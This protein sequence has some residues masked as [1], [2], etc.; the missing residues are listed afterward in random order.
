MPREV[1]FLKSAEKEYQD[2]TSLIQNDILEKAVTLAEFPFCGPLMG[3][4]YQGYRYLLAFRRQ[5]R[6]IYRVLEDETVEIAYIRHCKRQL[7]LRV[8]E[9]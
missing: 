1:R 7:G 4:S 3:R 2:L 6:I 9:A 5:Y 8:V